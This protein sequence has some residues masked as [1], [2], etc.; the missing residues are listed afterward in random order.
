MP[1][2]SAIGKQNTA[3]IYARYSSHNQKDASI[4]QQVEACMKKAE[5]KKLDVI[6]TYADRAIS[7][8][9]DNRPR[10][11]QMMKDAEEGKFRYVVAWKSNRMGRNM[12]QAMINAERLREC[13]VKVLYVE[14][15]F[16]DTAAGRF[17]LR[18]MMSVNQ[19]YIE[20]MAEDIHRGMMD[21]AKQCK[22]NGSP[23]YGYRIGKD[24]RFEVDENQAKIVQ[25]IFQKAAEGWYLI[26]ICRDLNR[27]GIKTRLGGQWNKS[28]FNKLLQNER[29]RGVYIF[30]DVRIDGGM[31]RIISDE[32]FYKVQ[33]ALR[34]KTNPRCS[35]RTRDNYVTYLLTGKLFCGHCKSPMTGASGTG[36]NGLYSYYRCQRRKT[37]HTC[38]K[39]NVQKE[40]IEDTIAKIIYNFCLTDDNIEVIADETVKYNA[41]RLKESNV[42]LLEEELED[43]NTRIGNLMKAMEAGATTRNTIARLNEL[44]DEQM[45][46]NIRLSDAKVNVVS[47]SKE[48]LVT[49]M[50]LFRKGDITNKKVQAKL[51]DT[52]LQ[53][54][55]LYDKKL[56]LVFNFTGTRNRI[57]VPI[58]NLIDDDAIEVLKSEID[59][60]MIRPSETKGHQ[61][62]YFYIFDVSY[63]KKDTEMLVNQASPYFFS[64]SKSID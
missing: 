44:E 1:R 23:P 37:D 51:F 6:E 18:N 60:D 38:D 9:T 35:G 59:T 62:V 4:E 5:A 47:C 29:Y 41:R 43:V 19:F 57:E 49:G 34:M 42:G 27:R 28:S 53:A 11:Q 26:D 20:N 45:K 61:I 50:R 40:W 12:L 10:F 8:K 32:L 13:G 55:F 24:K 21:N 25:E 48:Q 22:A 30:N 15:D 56:T 17:A 33:E 36:R 64:N 39:K 46:L 16:A 7:G 52:F 3:V 2:K 54:A 14:E 31:P 63:N 58:E